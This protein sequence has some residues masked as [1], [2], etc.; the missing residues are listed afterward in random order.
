MSRGKLW[1]SCCTRVCLFVTQVRDRD[2]ILVD[3]SQRI[4][5]KESRRIRA[6]RRER[7]CV[8]GRRGRGGG[9]PVWREVPPGSRVAGIPVP[10]MVLACELLMITAKE[11]S[12]YQIV[13]SV[14]DVLFTCYCV[15]SPRMI[16]CVQLCSDLIRLIP[17]LP[18]PYMC[19][20]RDA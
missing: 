16:C 17:T 15:M 3:T 20:E 1:R 14:L 10:L 13:G 18:P 6:V 12:R 11:K 7:E 8:P 4:R 9:P 2:E 5:W 19:N